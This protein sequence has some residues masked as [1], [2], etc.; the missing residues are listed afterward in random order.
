MIEEKS[1]RRST[2]SAPRICTPRRRPERDAKKAKE[3]VVQNVN[4][5]MHDLICVGDSDDRRK[6]LKTL[7]Q[8]VEKVQ[9]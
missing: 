3:E 6:R 1:I 2:R 7:R 8:C 4:E 5:S 9:K